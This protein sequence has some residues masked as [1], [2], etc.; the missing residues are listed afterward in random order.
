M[1]RRHVMAPR[2]GR[3]IDFKQWSSSP[4]LVLSTAGNSTFLSGSLGFTFPATLLRFR[5]S[6]TVAFDETKQIAD[7]AIITFGLAILSTDAVVSGS[8]S[9]P[10]PGTETEYPWIWWKEFFLQSFIAAAAEEW[11]STNRSAEVDSKAMRKIK[12]GESLVMVGEVSN[13]SGAP[14]IDLHIGQ[15]RVLIGT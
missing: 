8:G 11:G 13:S 1:A 3:R 7:Q 14:V 6:V 4:G 9:V 12:P 10:D 15:V 2:P 5:S